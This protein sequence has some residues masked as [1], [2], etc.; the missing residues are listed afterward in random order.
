MV[1]TGRDEMETVN[2]GGRNKG[3]RRVGLPRD[4]RGGGNALRRSAVEMIDMLCPIEI[5]ITSRR[6][7]DRRRLAAAGCASCF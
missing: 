5:S 6:E 7:T 1:D 2:R 4:M 3:N